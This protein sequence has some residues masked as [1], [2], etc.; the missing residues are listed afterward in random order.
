M[1]VKVWWVCYDETYDMGPYSS[2]CFQRA[3]V[4]SHPGLGGQD[5]RPGCSAWSSIFTCNDR[6]LA[7]REPRATGISEDLIIS[8]FPV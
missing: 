3:L 7:S 6:N 8:L 1:G 4:V 2:L 5:T